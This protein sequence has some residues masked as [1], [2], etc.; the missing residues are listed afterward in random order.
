MFGFN[1]DN[2]QGHVTEL[3]DKLK[4]QAGLSDD[5]AKQ[6]IET[7]KNFVVEKY[8]MLSGAVNNLFK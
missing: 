4:S 2:A 3:M 8:P 1:Q 6:V 7:I 5:Q